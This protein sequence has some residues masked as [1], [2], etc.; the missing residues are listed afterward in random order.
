MMKAAVAI[1]ILAIYWDTPDRVP[2]ALL[3]ASMFGVLTAGGGFYLAAQLRRSTTLF[4]T[5]AAELRRDAE[6]LAPSPPPA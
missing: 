3:L 4:V 2:A 5:S 6:A 1:L